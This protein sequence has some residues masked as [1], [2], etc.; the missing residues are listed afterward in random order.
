MSVEEK[1]QVIREVVDT[2]LTAWKDWVIRD[3]LI[4]LHGEYATDDYLAID[5]KT[6]IGQLK[7]FV[8]RFE[9]EVLGIK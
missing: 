1:K 8:A 6:N 9:M 7:E 4:E 5:G 2:E 3:T